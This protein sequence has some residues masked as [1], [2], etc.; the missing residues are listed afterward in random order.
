[1]AAAVIIPRPKFSQSAIVVGTLLAAWVLW[2]A[3]QNKL[4]VYWNLLLGRGAGGGGAGNPAPGQYGPP[5][6]A[7]PGANPTVPG[8]TPGDPLPGTYGPPA[9]AA[10]GGN[11]NVPTN[12]PG[13]ITGKPGGF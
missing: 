12:T 2:L 7:A 3:A 11:P 5:A 13:P 4:I 1:M 8:W 6:S 10:P 9:S